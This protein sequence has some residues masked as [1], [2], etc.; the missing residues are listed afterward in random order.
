MQ[1]CTGLHTENVA[2]GATENFQTVGGQRCT[3]YIN[4]PTIGG[5]GLEITYGGKR[6]PKYSSGRLYIVYI[7]TGFC[8]EWSVVV[9]PDYYTEPADHYSSSSDQLAIARIY[10]LARLQV[11]AIMAST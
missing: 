7:I 5:G 8:P 1:T 2:R 11:S 9:G 3:W 4:S 6:A 10:V